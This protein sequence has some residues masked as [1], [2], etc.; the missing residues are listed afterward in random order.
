[1]KTE[2]IPLS[3]GRSVSANN[4][5]LDWRQHFYRQYEVFKGWS[6]RADH[7]SEES[8]CIEMRRAGLTSG[9]RVLELGFGTGEFL[10][11]CQDQGCA[12]T[13]IEAIISLA[14][15]AMQRGHDV[16]IGDAVALLPTLDGEFD[17][18][19]AFDLFEHLSVNELLDLFANIRRILSPAGK[20]LA[21]FPNG[22]SPFSVVHQYGDMTHVTVL[23]PARID[24]IAK[25]SGLRLIAAYNSARTTKGKRMPRA[26]R[27]LAYLSRDVIETALGLIYYSGSRIPMDPNCTVILAKEPMT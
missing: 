21:R 15:A 14:K 7:F 12:V 23:S 2:N 11:W 10:D 20:I 22:A 26:L 16:R 4:V 9:D 19:V 8:Y 3:S 6:E 24:Q 5:M 17:L 27:T 18:V 13:G 1:M 25:S